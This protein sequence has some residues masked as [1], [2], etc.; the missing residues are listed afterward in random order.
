M[1][2]TGSEK[3]ILLML[4]ELYQKT[5]VD[6]DI[7]PE[8]IKQVIFSGHTWAL[9]MKYPGLFEDESPEEDI[10]VSNVYDILE[11][12][13]FIEESFES[14]SKTDQNA[15]NREA[16]P[17]SGDIKFPGFDGNTETKH[18]SI[19]RFMVT[20]MDF[21]EDFEEYDFNSH[22]PTINEH[23]RMLSAFENTRARLDGRLMN[24]AEL[25]E[26]LRER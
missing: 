15:V 18:M 19:A 25:I 1:K 2:F 13:S 9:P 11:M 14:L 10:T 7:N 17:H 16:N 23:S 8:F 26:V 21:F 4:S 24:P 20:Q 22:R 5:G 3:L 12:W 6:G